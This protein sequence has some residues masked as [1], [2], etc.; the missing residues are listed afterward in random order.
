MPRVAQ[1]QRRKAEHLRINLEEDVSSALGTGLA[2]YRLVH[3]ALPELSLDEIDT[4]LSL[5]G[6]TL[7]A[8][9][10]VSSMTGRNA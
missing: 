9:I 10:L 8:P 6:R 3:Q 4:G 2:R 7:R 1:V 5:F